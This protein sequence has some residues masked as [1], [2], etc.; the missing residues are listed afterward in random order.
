[1]VV[2]CVLFQVSMLQGQ[3]FY[4]EP[5]TVG[6]GRADD[7]AADVNG[8]GVLDFIGLASHV[9]LLSTPTGTWE[10]RTWPL[11]LSVLLAAGDVNAD[12]HVDLV[13]SRGGYLA[14][15]LGDGQG[16]WSGAITAPFV[17]GTAGPLPG[18][19]T[20]AVVDMDGDPWGDI[21]GDLRGSS[22]G[23]ARSYA[24]GLGGGFFLDVPFPVASGTI[25]PAPGDIDGDGDQDIVH[26]PPT[27]GFQVL[28]NDGLGG[29]TAGAI[30][31][32]P[33][34]TTTPPVVRD[35][36]GDGR[37]DVTY[38][39]TTG[40]LSVTGVGL[41]RSAPAGLIPSVETPI[42]PAMVSNGFL[43]EDLDGDG[44]GDVLVVGRNQLSVATARGMAM[45]AYGDV[46]GYRPP[47]ELVLPALRADCNLLRGD[48]DGDGDPDLV[49]ANQ[50]ATATDAWLNLAR[51]T[52]PGTSGG[53][54]GCAD[55][56]RLSVVG[57]PMGGATIILTL[58]GAPPSP[59][60]LLFVSPTLDH[61]LVPNTPC[62]IGLDLF[63]P[64]TFAVPHA[65]G[66]TGFSL[67]V[68]VPPSASGLRV[69]LQDA[70]VDPTAP[71]GIAIS[72]ALVV[73]IG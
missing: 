21:V 17:V 55:G 30:T 70:W 18:S 47:G 59:I 28:L 16:H 67:F 6:P 69:A 35:V 64:A 31:S 68:A 71:L 7:L 22:G 36:D 3:A 52:H 13:G 48:L 2:V 27:G 10:P 44:F 61:L 50:T 9:I 62:V 5:Y 41:L 11:D 39:C 49:F 63:N 43:V 34:P 53:F 40:F 32:L 56:S 73:L 15:L 12:G 60:A 54:G 72:P 25:S 14:V 19:A 37:A 45:V 29:L 46:A 51:G 58:F 26:S 8:D 33:T 57:T 20:L 24:R 66:T 38:L 23:G 4:G 42:V 1:L 65:I